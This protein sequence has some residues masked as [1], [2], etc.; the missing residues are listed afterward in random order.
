MLSDKIQTPAQV[1][2]NIQHG[3]EDDTLGH[4]GRAKRS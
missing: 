4:K 2:S 3:K 1:Q